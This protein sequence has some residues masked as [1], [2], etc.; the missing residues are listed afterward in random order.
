[1]TSKKKINLFAPAFTEPGIYQIKNIKTG[2]VYIGESKYCLHRLGGHLKDLF[3]STHH[4]AA[5]QTDFIKTRSSR[6]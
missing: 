1:M 3:N 4:C 6:F 2:K 5:L